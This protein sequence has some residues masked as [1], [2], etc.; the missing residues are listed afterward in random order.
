MDEL[1][2]FLQFNGLALLV[3][4]GGVA[5]AG[6]AY[7]RFR[8]E[9][10]WPL[11]FLLGA[12]T[13]LLLGTG[14]LAGIHDVLGYDA[15]LYGLLAAGGAL[16]LMFLV[17]LVL[18]EWF[19]PLGWLVLAALL[20]MLGAWAGPFAS[21]GVNLGIRFLF[22][23]QPTEPSWLILLLGIPLLVWFSFRS[24]SGL[25]PVRRVVALSLRSL[26]IL[27]LVLAL[28]DTHARR[29]ED[30]LTVLFLYDRSLSVPPELDDRNVDVR[31]ERIFDFI[32]AAVEKRGG[33]KQGDRA[34]VIVFGRHPRLELPPAN[35]PKLRFHKIKSPIDDTHTD[36]ASALKLAL[37]SFP[38]GTSKRI[39]LI[40]DGNENIGQ[41]EEQA[42]IAKQNGVQIDVLPLAG[43]KRNLNEVLVERIEAPPSTEKFSRV[44]LR[45]VLRSFN[46]NLV[47]GTLHLF[48]KGLSEG[49][50]FEEM[51]V[52]STAVKLR[53]GLNIFYYQQ[54]GSAAEEAV[55]YEAKFDPSHVENKRGEIVQKDFKDDRKENNRASVSVMS[56]GDRAILL[57]E[58]KPGSHKLLADRLQKAKPSLKILTRI[59]A[60]LPQD[61]QELAL[62]LNRFDLVVMANIPAESRDGPDGEIVGLTED[63]QK[64]FRSQVH[65]QG[66]GLITI[67]GD[68]GYGAGGWQGTELEKAWPVT[69]DLKSM[70]V[71]GKSG[72]VL[73]MHASEM[74]DGNAWQK[75]IAK[76]AIEKLSPMD[77]IGVL[78][79]DH[80]A[81]GGGHVWHIPFQQIADKKGQLIGRLDQMIPGDMPDAEPSFKMAFGELTKRKYQLGTKHII[82]IS[83]GDHWNV[84]VGTLQRVG[85]AN[86]SC[87]TVCITTHGQ[88]EVKKLAAVAQI[89]E[90][91]MQNPRDDK[92]GRRC[93][94]YHVKDPSQLPA[95]Y[96]KEARLVSQSFVHEKKFQPEVLL[97]LGPTEGIAAVPPLY[98]FVRTTKRPSALVETP[99]KTPK[100]GDYTFPILAYWQYG[101]GKS[102]AFTSDARSLLREGENYWDKDWASS[103]MYARFW[104]QT[105]DFALR[106][107]DSGKYLHV[108]TEQKDGKVRIIV[109]AN[110]SDQ[111]TKPP[112]TDVKF[113]V[114][115][116]SPAFKAAEGNKVEITLEQ[117]SAGVYEGEFQADEVGTYFLSIQ[118]KWDKTTKDKEGKTVVTPHTE[119]VRAGVTIPYSPEF[120][121]M[122]GNSP[123][124]ER[125]KKMTDGIQYEDS[126]DALM[127]AALRGDVFRTNPI[128][129]Q[130]LQPLWFWLVLL[131]GICLVFDVA[132]RRI[133]IEPAAA[134]NYAVAVWSRLRRQEAPA[135]TTVFLER[136]QSRKATVGESLEKKKA[137]KR[138]EAPEGAPSAP[139]PEASASAPA[140]PTL[141]KPAPAPKKK[142][143]EAADFATRLMRAKKKA[144]EDRDKPS[145]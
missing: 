12:A 96:I 113:K 74:A 121:E 102:I 43:G 75:K 124:L 2:E 21:A 10:T 19:A 79:F 6:V 36:I 32:N 68:N 63:Q 26:L 59:P 61:P 29:P 88:A 35:V 97:R 131:A 95:I 119:N 17:L 42:R 108:T 58:P 27:L 144:M 89:V 122:E 116:S 129:H 9:R 138:F 110:D 142:E 3:L 4:L 23:L 60:Q 65:D 109:E 127:Q 57:L 93:N 55:T 140:G 54:P 14:A 18:G 139:V 38:E 66:V 76:L 39:V 143:E 50:G 135:T 86:I 104:E 118:A 114:G 130:S 112:L 94:S 85:A 84:P 132:V 106:P 22:T 62:F 56:R 20:F 49:K 64:V 128:S 99:I 69:C 80:G 46:P 51:P 44:P 72:L 15:A 28:A 47:V 145:K 126:A 8:S 83:D 34:G 90:S 25:G 123:L 134:A 13:L 120:A 141:K 91:A 101:L 73:I 48:K 81:A 40:S 16:F 82:F 37:A 98:G 31:E 24:L 137:A 107:V 78:Y 7:L 77:M 105:V 45:I 1:L 71:E 111:A 67:G 33:L 5:L 117:K 133:A 30:N 41:A 11:G 136:L 52:F 53:T 70:K 92:G 115:I 87:T 103:D 100:I 125:L